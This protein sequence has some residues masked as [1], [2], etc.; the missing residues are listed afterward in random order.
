MRALDAGSAAQRSF[1]GVAE[2]FHTTHGTLAAASL[3]VIATGLALH[4]IAPDWARVVW[5][6]G[7]VVTGAPVVWRTVLETQRGRW[8]TDVVAVL[9]IIAAVLLRQPIAGLVIVLMRSGG[10]ALEQFAAG[11]A[12]AALREL[13]E[14]APRVA[15]RAGGADPSTTE[16][17]PVSSIGIGDILLVR[18]G[19]IVPSDCLVRDGRSLVDVARLTGE[20]APIEAAVGTSLMS[21]SVNGDGVLTVTAT[22]RAEESQYARIVELVRS[23]Q[24]SKAPLARL[25]DQYAVWFTPATLLVCLVT[26]LLTRDTTRVLAVLVVAT[27]CPLILATPIAIMGGISRAARRQIIVRH[28]GA[29]EAL[30]VVD[31]AVFD[32]TGTLTIGK[33]EVSRALGTAAWTSDEVLRLAGAVEQ[34][35]SHLLARSLVD[36]AISRCGP[37]PLARH[38]VE[39]LLNRLAVG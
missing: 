18:P 37:L 13:E 30:S 16:D 8:A 25:A 35:S 38:H 36:A 5:L 33:P 17:I 15:H 24:A 27:P 2:A 34:G 32:K 28:G 31:T 10:E 1:G 20:P 22:A 4:S 12:S 29:L 23:A 14:A 21:G 39:S 6:A 9:A 19:E 11:R 7:L 3:V 26:Y